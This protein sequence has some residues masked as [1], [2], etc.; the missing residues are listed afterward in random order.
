MDLILWR[1]A[2]AEDAYPDLSR[3]LTGKGRKQASRI[4]EWLNPRLPEDI[5]IIASPAVRTVQT[6]Q[7]L[8]RE[9]E[10]VDACAPGAT[11]ARIL[12]VAGW[13]DTARPVLI[14]GHQPVLGQIAARLLFGQ[15][16]E[17]SIR[18]AAV[19]W[20]HGRDRSESEVALRAVVNPDWL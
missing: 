19:W 15:E 20:F 10:V 8:G 1:H 16:A 3:A 5:R 14:V 13:P 9:F 4:A 12:E 11:A 17:L 18:K 6:A 7:A 2:E